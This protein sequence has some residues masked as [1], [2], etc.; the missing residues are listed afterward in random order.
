MNAFVLSP[1]SFFGSSLSTTPKC[2]TRVGVSLAMSAER[3][4][5]W[6]RPGDLRTVDHPGLLAVVE[7]DA[8]AAV[9][10]VD[11]DTLDSN[12]ILALESALRRKQG[13][14]LSLV[15]DDGD[16][17]SVA[18][19]VKFAKE[20]EATSVHVRLDETE[21]CRT[22][23]NEL[24]NLL[25][26]TVVVNTWQDEYRTWGEEGVGAKQLAEIPDEYPKFK[27]WRNAKSL[28]IQ[29]ID[30]DITPNGFLPDDA[31]S[32][33]SFPSARIE[34]GERDAYARF[35]DRYDADSALSNTV[36]VNSEDSGSGDVDEFGEYIL[37][38]YLES[39]DDNNNPDLARSL[40][41]IFSYGLLSPRRI[42]EVVQLYERENGRLWRAIYR[43]GAKQVLDYLDAREFAQLLARRDLA[44]NYTVDGVHQA[45]FWR[46]KGYLVR[47]VMEGPADPNLPTLLLVHGFGASVQHWRR[48][49]A[50][51]K[52]EYNVFALD[53]VGYGRSEKP[54]TA[55]TPELWGMVL[56][57]FVKEVVQRPVYIAGNSI[58]GYFAAAFASDAYPQ[59]C[60]G[61]I[62]VNSAGKLEDRPSE[63]P[64]EA[65]PTTTQKPASRSFSPLTPIF[66]A[67]KIV[68]ENYRPARMFAANI[69]LNNLRGRIQKT[70][71]MVYPTNPDCADE[72][73]AR[74][75]Y[76]NSLDFG[77]DSVLASGLVLPPPRS[78]SELLQNYQ[79]ELLVYQGALDPL[80][81]SSDRAE[82][83]RNEYPEGTWV[84]K[85]QLG[86]CPHEEDAENFA[87][88]VSQWIK[89]RN[90]GK[91]VRH[92]V[93]GT[94][95]SAEEVAIQVK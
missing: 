12:I 92:A 75:I 72:E 57:D 26:D 10:T 1:P 56:F 31:D 30:T 21:E 18:N 76:R 2:K 46:W 44:A 32:N 85:R 3:S 42:R 43:D 36:A 52:K 14:P 25:P 69:L 11:K 53:L 61:L 88:T 91:Y 74:E 7:S 8:A 66:S 89:E 51:L 45:R 83:I 15:T 81:S 84:E 82:K 48:S 20:F 67:G 90:D 6:I 35:V 60:A 16:A 40:A 54:P 17:S 13:I 38:R 87:S 80:N 33:L 50:I 64:D 63:S 19:F 39:C 24:A 29:P 73:L 77:A 95:S 9:V 70:L 79:G 94:S 49:M 86:H 68:L 27:R 28:S 78:L 62:L 58:G 41:P 65:T 34:N 4:V 22:L 23:V 71:Q 47:Y 37:R 55:Y 59:L 5:V 93:E